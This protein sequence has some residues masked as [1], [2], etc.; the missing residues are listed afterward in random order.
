MPRASVSVDL[1]QDLHG[2]L[3]VAV[4]EGLAR[5]LGNGLD[6]LDLG[7][8]ELREDLAG[9]RLR[10]LMKPSMSAFRA[11]AAEAQSRRQDPDREQGD[12]L[13]A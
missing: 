7:G 5:V 11:L 9:L 2:K 3:G 10:N 13:L 4:G 8:D 1:A 6:V 12:P